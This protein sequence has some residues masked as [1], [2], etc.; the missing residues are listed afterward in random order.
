MTRSVPAMLLLVDSNVDR[1]EDFAFALGTR[2]EFLVQT[3][4]S[5]AE[6]RRYLRHP[7]LVAVVCD[8][9]GE[10]GE[11]G[12]A[13]LRELRSMLD[14]DHVAFVLMTAPTSSGA[15][16]GAWTLDTDSVLNHPI[17]SAELQACVQACMRRRALQ[18]DLA[19]EFKRRGHDADLTLELLQAGLDAV[20]PE[21]RRRGNETVAIAERLAHELHVPPELTA[22]LRRA[23]LLHEIGRFVVDPDV[24]EVPGQGPSPALIAA[25]AALLEPIPSLSNAAELI[26]GMGA[27]WDGSAALTHMERG[28]IPMRSRILRSVVDYLALRRLTPDLDDQG[29]AA[30]EQL[31]LHSGTRYDPAV[32]SELALVVSTGN[33]EGDSIRIEP[34]RVEQLTEGRTLV[35]DLCTASGV[36]LLSA[37]SVLTAASLRLIAERH[38]L[39][40]IVH[41]V[42]TRRGSA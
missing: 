26:E 11:D 24:A 15:R 6:A 2:T 20:C 13:L 38:A 42:A 27:N 16:I 31:T 40:P 29:V 18:A 10:R 8:E 17:H 19:T 5:L 37:G 34:L 25:S 41:A 22:E 35:N 36:K 9:G 33:P 39:D 21:A 12:P 3:A 14:V 7:E 32:L 23:A 28:A 1:C 4:H 30:C